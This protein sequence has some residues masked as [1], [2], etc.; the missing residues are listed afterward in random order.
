MDDE[1][2][3]WDSAAFYLAQ[4]CSSISLAVSPHLI[5]LG[6]GIMQR[7]CLFP[8]IR[9]YLLASLNHYLTSPLLTGLL[10]LFFNF[11]AFFL[12][13]HRRRRSG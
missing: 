8:K 7:E 13:L 1:D 6:G 10:H 4:L 11:L 9:K 5:V 3:I 12:T 2:E